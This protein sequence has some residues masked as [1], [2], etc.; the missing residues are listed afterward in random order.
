DSLDASSAS[1]PK[2]YAEVVDRDTWGPN[3][4]AVLGWTVDT[5]AQN[6][7]E[8]IERIH[9]ADRATFQ[10]V[11]DN[12]L[13]S[14]E[15]YQIEFRFRNVDGTY[16]WVEERGMTRYNADGVPVQVI[17]Y[18]RDISNRKAA[19]KALTITQAAV[20]LAAESIFWVMPNGRF[21]YVNEAACSGLGYSRE[22]L[23]NLSV[24]DI[25]YEFPFKNWES[26]WHALQQRS[27]FT[28][29]SHHQPKEGASYPVE[30]NVNYVTFEGEEFAFAFARDIRD[31]K[32][33]EAALIQSEAKSR[34]ILAAIP[35]RI[36]RVGRDGVYRELVTNRAGLKGSFDGHDPAY[37]AAPFCLPTDIIAPQI[38]AIEHA[39]STTT[40]QVYE[41]QIQDVIQQ[42]YEE[43]R[44]I[45]SGEDEALLMIRDISDRKQAEAKLRASRA[46]YRTIVTDQTELI[47]R[48]LPDGTLSF[49]NDAYCNYFQ[50]TP[51]ELI[52]SNF[53]H[54]MP[55]EERAI[56]LQK[57]QSLSVAKPVST[58]EHQVMSPNGGLCWQQ[59]TDRALFDPE[60]NL[61]EFQS[62]GRDVTPL[63][64]TEIALRESEAR[65]QFALEG[66]GQGVWDWHLQSNEMFY[67]VCLKTMLGYTDTEMPNNPEAWESLIHPEDKPYVLDQWQQ[68]LRGEITIYRNEYRLRCKDG[69]YKW[70]LGLGKAVEWKANGNPLRVIGTHTDITERRQ[71]EQ[72][73]RLL[74]SV[75]ESS[76]DAIITVSLDGIIT[77]WNRAAVKLFGYAA[78]EALHQS[79]T[80]LFPPD[81]TDELARV[82][83][84]LSQGERIEPF[85]TVRWRKG[86]IPV[87]VA[88]TVSAT[89][90]EQGELTGTSAIIRDI[91]ERKQIAAERLRA[92]E[93]RKALELLEQI[94]DNVL[95][96]YWDWHIPNHVKYLSP[97]FKHM[98]GYDDHELPNIPESCQ[99]LLLPEDRQIAQDCF[100][101]HIQSR[102]RIPYY[103][104]V[105]YR[106]KNGSSVWVIASGQVIE[107]DD[108]GAPVRMIGCHIDISDRK[109]AEEA[110]VQQASREKLLL[111]IGQ[112]IRQS[113][114]IQTIFTTAC[115]EIRSVT[116]VERV[117]IFQFHPDSHLTEDSFVDEPAGAFV[118]ESVVPPFP[119]VLNTPVH[120]RCFGGNYAAIYTQGQFF[121]VNDVYENGLSPCHIESLEKLQI[122]ANLVVPLVCHGELWGLLCLDHCSAAR[123]WQPTEISLTQQLATQLM[124]ALQQANLF[125]QLQQELAERLQVQHQLSERNQELAISNQEL[126]RATRLKDQFL[127]NMSHELR[128]PL[129]AILGMTEGLKD[130]AFGVITPDQVD[131]LNTVERSGSHLLALINDIL[132]VAKIESGQIVLNRISLPVGRL[133]QSSLTFIR[134]PALK[135][136]I[137][138]D[139]QLPG[140]LPHVWADERRLRQVLLNLLDNAVK[141]TPEGG[142]ITLAVSY[143]LELAP[144]GGDTPSPNYVQIAVSDT[145]IGIA[146]DHLDN[147]FQPFVQIDSALNRQYTGTGLGLALVKRL[148]ELHEGQVAITS[149][150]GVGSCFT[151]KIPCAQTFTSPQ[152]IPHP[153]ST[154]EPDPVELVAHPLILLAEDNEA[155]IKTTSRY[156]IAKGYRVLLAKTGQEAITITQAEHPD[157]IL[158]DI[159]M[160]GLDGLEAIQ[161]IRLNPACEHLPIIALTALAMSGDRDRCIAAGA[162]EYLSKPIRLQQLVTT[163]QRLLVNP[164]NNS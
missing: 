98:F 162:N 82:H 9:P 20:D 117:S 143:P 55:P 34:A 67:S 57:L 13:T 18:L 84:C 90:N 38:H 70:I 96:G 128:T 58:Y 152:T 159:Q 80:I 161:Q 157:L 97:G 50:K 125:R 142:R 30:I 93:T 139:L 11:I 160:P 134:Q 59:W 141:F 29:E 40:L 129:N 2:S 31:R 164:S 111:E 158:M 8:H 54:L 140:Q 75:V 153:E 33:A 63:K 79:V 60:G 81:R 69:S 43:V 68:Y 47:C 77:S 119:S 118:A 66:G 36:L 130:S 154:W 53:L 100:D 163:I 28:F 133:C 124:I 108:T 21:K 156:L 24:T 137:Q 101:L 88:V 14:T 41:Q 26:Q 138:I 144:K 15:P 86:Q 65:W 106:H 51:Q 151:L 23:L 147:L 45:K 6:L 105:R 127:A 19:A 5:M 17:G 49:V 27:N 10:A 64:E 42:R 148:V 110:L 46:F 32:Q 136:R 1:K 104:E 116:D 76:T 155:N 146:P 87:E 102:G 92:E 126:A 4:E 48:F 149:E 120:D 135:K 95:A 72:E 91:T 113:L 115:R 109:Q 83:E 150:V 25:D 16:R 99:N 7:R 37:V 107:W 132:D 112:R 39:L 52:G 61:L 22:E 122:R 78:A 85:E 123:E 71:R 35:D 121:A 73:S 131:A 103:N 62:V 114:N 74:A 56:V 12:D 145:G 94:V 89:R 3:L 44:V